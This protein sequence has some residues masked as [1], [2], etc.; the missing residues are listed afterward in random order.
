MRHGQGW[1]W[2]ALAA[3]ALIAQ[4]GARAFAENRRDEARPTATPRSDDEGRKSDG[5]SDEGTIRR[6]FRS[7]GKPDRDHGDSGDRGND[8]DRDRDADRDR[9]R[10]RGSDRRSSDGDRDRDDRGSSH[11]D[12]DDDRSRDRAHDRDGDRSRDDR[13]DR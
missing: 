6:L 2:A 3:A 8:R 12:R 4:T 10:D 11:R 7:I 13:R 1:L 9:D 5:G